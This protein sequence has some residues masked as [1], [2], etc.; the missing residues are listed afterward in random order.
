MTKY[1]VVISASAQKDI[2]EIAL[3]ISKTLKNPTASKKLIKKLKEKIL[4][5]NEFPYRALEQCNDK[6]L[7]TRN[8]RYVIV[9]NYYIF[10]N[11]N[12]DKNQVSIVRVIYRKRNWEEIFHK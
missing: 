3:Y 5:L 10:L 8:V 4:S 7:T 1:K 2:M 9:E 11:V 6:E 12:E